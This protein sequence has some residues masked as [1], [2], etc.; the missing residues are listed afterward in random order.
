MNHSPLSQYLPSHSIFL[1]LSLLSILLLISLSSSFTT[2]LP[3]RFLSLSHFF[4]PLYFYFLSSTQIFSSFFLFLFISSILFLSLLTFLTHG[5]TISPC[6]SCFHFNFNPCVSFSA[7]T[8]LNELCSTQ[9]CIE[10]YRESC[11]ES[12]R[13]S[14]RL[15]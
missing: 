2:I 4:L 10:S 11:I 12:Y 9:V 1:Y 13:E 3:P 7:I 15:N 6:I 8:R 14:Y 5:L